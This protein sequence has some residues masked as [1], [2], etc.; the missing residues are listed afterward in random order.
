MKFYTS[1]FTAIVLFGLC[2]IEKNAKEKMLL[3][4]LEQKTEV[5]KPSDA[6]DPEFAQAASAVDSVVTLPRF[7]RTLLNVSL[8]KFLM[9]KP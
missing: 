5:A 1:I 7:D 2:V 8:D 6:G 9:A 4:T 3:K